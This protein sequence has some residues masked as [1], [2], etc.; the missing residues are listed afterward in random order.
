ML[1]FAFLYDEAEL[2][3]AS[4]ISRIDADLIDPG[5]DGHQGEAIVEMD[6]GDDRNVRVLLD[7]L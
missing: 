7:F 3:L 6:I 4:D 2:I 5:I 1:L